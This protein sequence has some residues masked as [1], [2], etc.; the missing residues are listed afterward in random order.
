MTIGRCVEGD[1][2]CRALEVR[3]RAC[4][5]VDV[6]FGTLEFYACWNERTIEP[7]SAAAFADIEIV[8]SRNERAFPSVPHAES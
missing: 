1:A 5:G 3:L 8:V 4:L 6:L 7:N 2:A